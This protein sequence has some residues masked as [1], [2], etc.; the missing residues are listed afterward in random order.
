MGCHSLFQR[1]FLNQ[2]SYLGLLHCKQALYHLSHQEALYGVC[3]MSDAFIGVIL[4]YACAYAYMLLLLL[5][6][7]FSHVQLCVT[8]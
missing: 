1:I 3:T 6:S 2:G 7:R 5:L 4:H 8:P